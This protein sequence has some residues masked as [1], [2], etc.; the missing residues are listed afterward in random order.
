MQAEP[1][2]EQLPLTGGVP[3]LA[4]FGPGSRYLG[5][6]ISLAGTAVAAA[7]TVLV[8][9]W[10]GIVPFAGPLFGFG[11]TG[12]PSWHWAF[13]DAVLNALPGA[14]AVGCGIAMLLSLWRVR[15]A[16][17]RVLLVVAG[18]MAAAAGGWL[19][20]GPWAL[21]LMSS[22]GA[23]STGATGM[24]GPSGF[25]R[26]V[27]YHL[28]TGM[29]LVASGTAAAVLGNQHRTVRFAVLRVR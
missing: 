14:L 3:A 23:G 22:I 27:G 29:L 7:T 28:G 24:V 17:G 12:T 2:T 21:P 26:L 13:A 18:V 1:I 9:A 4:Q 15:S 11:L 6:P 5:L 10:S 25:A 8:G 19:V 20:L 16:G